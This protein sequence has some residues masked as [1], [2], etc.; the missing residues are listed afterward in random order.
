MKTQ[1]ESGFSTV[2]Q[3]LQGWSDE[4]RGHRYEGVGAEYSLLGLYRTE[5]GAS[6]KS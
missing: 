1:G 3:D 4:I 6:E 5:A 2:A